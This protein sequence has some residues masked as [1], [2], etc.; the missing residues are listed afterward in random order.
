MDEQ[1]MIALAKDDAEWT[2]L[3]TASNAEG[4][5]VTRWHNTVTDHYAVSFEY[6]DGLYWDQWC[7]YGTGAEGERMSSSVFRLTS[8]RYGKAV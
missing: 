6:A 4:D 2:E 3:A 1:L 7:T 5:N 8:E